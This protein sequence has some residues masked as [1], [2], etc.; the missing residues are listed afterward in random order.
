M[1]IISQKAWNPADLTG[2][3]VDVR[4]M[5]DLAR[6]RQLGSSNEPVLLLLPQADSVSAPVSQQKLLDALC[7]IA[8]AESILLAGAVPVAAE[9]AIQVVG[10]L[11]S[12]T[13]EV[14]L[15]TTKLSPNL[16]N[17]IGPVDTVA[18]RCATTFPVATTEIGQIGILSGEDILVPQFAR[19]LTWSGAE[20]ILNPVSEVGDHLFDGRRNARVARAWENTSYVATSSP[21]DGPMAGPVCSCLIDWDGVSTEADGPAAVLIPDLDIERLR[22]RRNAVFGVQPLHLRAN[23]FAD[24]YQRQIDSRVKPLPTLPPK[25]REAW[26]EEAE[27]RQSEMG[28]PPATER[29]E[30]YDVVLAQTVTKI[31]QRGDDVVALRNDN[32]NR[33]ISLASRLAASPAVKLV[34]MGEF[35]IHGQGGHGFRSPITLERLAI[36]YPGPE[37]ELL[38]D[39]AL[40]HSVYVA[41]SSF[42]IDDKFPG[43]VFNSAFI[44]DDTGQLIH[45]YRKIQCADVWGS[46]PDT[47]PSSIYDRYLDTYGYD[48][49]FPVAD[50]PI[51]RLGTMVCFDQAHP[52]IARMLT[53]YGAEVIIHPTS[54]G[55]GGPRQG[56]DASRQTRAFEN[57]AYVVSAM[58]GGEY[59]NPSADELPTTQ[60]RG[61]SRII[62]FDG[63]VLGVADGPGAC[64]LTGSI[65]LRALQRARANPQINLVLWDDP[66]VYAHAYQGDVGLPNNLWGADPLQNPYVGFGPLRAALDK[67]YERGI[68]VRPEGL[69]PS[70]DVTSSKVYGPTL[71]PADSTGLAKQER[72]D[73][74]FIQI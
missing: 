4:N 45:R 55:H 42:E 8:D 74:E 51:G 11:L 66:E 61:H 1:F 52:E 47:T 13:G 40:K 10:F 2:L 26:A 30:Q 15:S 24:G 22:R 53:K 72:L 59:F 71:K 67:Y 6:R 68:F 41:G 5:V 64:T 21:V 39:F 31:I 49:L 46:L 48:F 3:S 44:I 18:P 20:I 16:V 37:L 12:S 23:L 33:A 63:A 60:L 25:S 70:A 50:T 43:H 36:R 7:D 65:D 34:V 9:A 73:G 29:I 57:T 58:P 56:W 35:F 14:L 17:G 32:I 38:Q 62:G 28:E 27:I 69:D 19:A 54:E